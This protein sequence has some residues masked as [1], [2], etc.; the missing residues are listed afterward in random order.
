MSLRLTAIGE[1]DC[2]FDYDSQEWSCSN[3]AR[4]L[5]NFDFVDSG[6]VDL[7]FRRL[8]AGLESVMKQA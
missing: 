5:L 4:S 8:L 3:A 2:D 6:V 1:F 7:E